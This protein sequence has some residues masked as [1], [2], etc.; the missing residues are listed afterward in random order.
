[1]RKKTRTRARVFKQLLSW[2]KMSIVHINGAR[3]QNIW[4]AHIHWNEYESFDHSFFNAKKQDV[5]VL[6]FVIII[7]RWEISTNMYENNNSMNC[8]STV[9]CA[10][11]CI[12]SIEQVEQLFFRSRSS[13]ERPSTSVKTSSIFIS[14]NIMIDE[15]NWTK[16]DVKYNNDKTDKR[17]G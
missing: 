2:K 9:P 11:I 6:L 7:R 1:M 3:S 13:W 5:Y 4:S 10:S 12:H 14:M 8:C 17:H 16:I 15:C